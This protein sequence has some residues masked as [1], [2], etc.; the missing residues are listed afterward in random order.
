M[1]SIWF[2]GLD[3]EEKTRHR[4]LISIPRRKAMYKK[5]GSLTKM[6]TFIFALW[7]KF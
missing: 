5:Y 7:G 4:P 1:K 3:V 2:P 6:E